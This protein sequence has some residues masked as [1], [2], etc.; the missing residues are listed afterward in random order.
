ML[1]RSSVWRRGNNIVPLGAANAPP[2]GFRVD[3]IPGTR[4]VVL[5]KDDG[6][7][8]PKVDVI[9]AV[10]QTPIRSTAGPGAPGGPSTKINRSKGEE[11]IQDNGVPFFYSIY[12]LRTISFP[13]DVVGYCQCC[14][15]ICVTKSAA[16]LPPRIASASSSSSAPLNGFSDLT[17][18]EDY[19][20]GPRVTQ[21]SLAKVVLDDA[22]LARH[23]RFSDRLYPPADASF[24]TADHEVDG[25][26]RDRDAMFGHSPVHTVNADVAE[27][28]GKLLELFGVDDRLAAFVETHAVEEGNCNSSSVLNGKQRNSVLENS[29]KQTDKTKQNKTKHINNEQRHTTNISSQV[30]PSLITNMSRQQLCLLV[31]FPISLSP[32]KADPF[33]Q[34]AAALDELLR[35]GRVM[36]S[37]LRSSGFIHASDFAELTGIQEEAQE[38]LTIVTDAVQVLH[39]SGGR[40][41]GQVLSANEMVERQN[42]VRGFENEMEELNRF[43]TAVRSTRQASASAESSSPADDVLVSSDV[44]VLQ[45]EHAQEA[46]MAHQEEVMDRLAFGLQELR[47]TG[48]NINDELNTQSVMLQEVDTSMTAVQARLQSAN[49]KL[50]DLLAS[51]SNKGKIC[52]LCALFGVAMF[53]LFFLV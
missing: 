43:Y 24:F 28:V 2:N 35:R 49:R 33:L 46:E 16:F 15:G 42:T 38:L 26:M 17:F 52:T 14:L 23:H 3:R 36:R 10:Q 13:F 6:Y 7:R 40:I 48:I 19:Y 20:A 25:G 22:P 45:Q 41:N 31:C 11:A 44:Y 8:S 32:T 1:K 29:N 21:T 34:A 12:N 50:D 9:Y 51:L 37:R 18:L 5:R 47:A 4:S 27:S 30:S 39:G 53:L